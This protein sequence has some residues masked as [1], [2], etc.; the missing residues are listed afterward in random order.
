MAAQSTASGR[1]IHRLHIHDGRLFHGGG[2]ANANT[3]PIQLVSLDLDDP[4]AD[5]V[6]EITLQTEA[7][8]NMR[9]A[10]NGQMLV[11]Y[12][13]PQGTGDASTGALAI[14]AADGS[15]TVVQIS[16]HVPIHDFSSLVR[17][18]GEV[19]VVGASSAGAGAWIDSVW[20]PIADA[21]EGNPSQGFVRA[22][23]VL[24]LAGVLH[25]W[26]D[27]GISSLDHTWN[28]HYVR[29]D[30][31]GTWAK[32]DDDVRA[33]GSTKITVNGTVRALL[34]T[35]GPDNFETVHGGQLVSHDGALDAWETNNVY[36]V[37]VATDGSAWWLT[38][39]PALYRG[40]P[41]GSSALIGSIDDDTVRSLAVDSARGW[42]YLGTT[43]SRI[44]RVA[45]P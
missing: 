42:V 9:T 5:P 31:D 21:P 25:A 20:E 1:E 22:W 44:V 38:T 36:A 34:L 15:W 19:V 26:V 41:D 43:D 40:D 37:N 16:D 45:V 35:S 6:E 33:K 10:P 7:V 8:W 39:E 14:K 13:D 17:D 3:G 4:S 28:G 29:D 32:V 30:S 2:D 18:T 11:S 12:I 23:T 27:D 24:E